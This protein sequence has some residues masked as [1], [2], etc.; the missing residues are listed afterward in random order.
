L[1]VI[2]GASLTGAMVMAMVSVSD[3]LAVAPARPE[4]PWSSVVMLR[5]SVPW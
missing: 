2:T 5:A 3:R 4:W 1:L